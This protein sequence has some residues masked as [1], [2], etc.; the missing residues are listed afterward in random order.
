M[1]H[2]KTLIATACTVFAAL[3][4]LPGCFPKLER[5]FPVR[6][7]YYLTV[8]RPGDPAEELL[9]EGQ[10]VVRPL[11]ISPAFD[12]RGFVHRK[13]GNKLRGDFYNLF[14]SAPAPMITAEV[15]RWLDQS[16]RFDYVSGASS[17]SLGQYVL[18]GNIAAL[19]IDSTATPNIAVLEIQFVLFDTVGVEPRA[20]LQR[21]YRERE[22]MVSTDRSIHPAPIAWSICLERILTE[23]ENDLVAIDWQK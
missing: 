15:R 12:R 17:L 1:M 3:L 6:D 22:A 20:I 5:Q 13:A 23:L 18:E 7:E 2:T 19:Y 10:L 21:T 9:A 4:F 8:D 11:R 14:F 16:G